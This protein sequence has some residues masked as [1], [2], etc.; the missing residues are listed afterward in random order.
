MESAFLAGYAV[1]DSGDVEEV[2]S[3]LC[4]K[5]SL[6]H[7][8]VIEESFLFEWLFTVFDRVGQEVSHQT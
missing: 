4:N 7:F 5:L 6:G 8:I 1:Q 3:N 2:W